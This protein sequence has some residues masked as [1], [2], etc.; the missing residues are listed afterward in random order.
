MKP[1]KDFRTGHNTGFAL[2]KNI[3]DSSIKGHNQDERQDV[4]LRAIQRGNND[5]AMKK[6][7]E[8]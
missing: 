4:K 5:K 1:W 8:N 7:K 3:S 6:G 2:Y